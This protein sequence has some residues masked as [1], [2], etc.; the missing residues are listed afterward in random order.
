[1]K[2][3]LS[4]IHSQ[5]KR[6]C[7]TFHSH[8]AED[9][10]QRTVQKRSCYL[11]NAFISSICQCTGKTAPGDTASQV[12]PFSG[13]Q[14]KQIENRNKSCAGPQ[15]PLRISIIITEPIEGNQTAN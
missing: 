8:P 9:A 4:L 6:M 3:D 1:M 15:L 10:E 14:E 2:E 12:F 7:E 5:L 11:T 13:I